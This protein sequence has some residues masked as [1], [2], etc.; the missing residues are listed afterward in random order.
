MPYFILTTEGCIFE[1][2]DNID[3]FRVLGENFLAT[4][5][6]LKEGNPPTNGP[7]LNSEMTISPFEG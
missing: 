2:E 4:Y 1:A 6:S 5:N 3:I 7:C